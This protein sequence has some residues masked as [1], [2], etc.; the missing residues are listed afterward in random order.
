MKKIVVFPA[1]AKPEEIET[2]VTTALE[3][4]YRH[5]DTATNYNNEEA[6]G[7]ALKK[8]FN[9]GGN[10]AELFITTKVAY[11]KTK[12]PSL[13]VQILIIEESR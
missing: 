3:C 7:K 9:K 8:W 10:R 13:Y 12:Y 5:I 4:G 2:V 1:Q 11:R 6:I